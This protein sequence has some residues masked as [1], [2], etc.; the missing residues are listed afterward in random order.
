MIEDQVKKFKIILIGLLTLAWLSSPVA[1]DTSLHGQDV[2]PGVRKR[3]ERWRALEA[4]DP[5]K[6]RELVQQRKQEIRRRMLRLRAKDPTRFNALREELV[7]RRRERLRRLREENPEQFQ[8]VM[9][10]KW[11]RFEEWKRKNPTP[12]QAF[13]R[14]HPRLAE[15][16]RTHEE[17]IRAWAKRRSEHRSE[18]RWTHRGDIRKQ[19]KDRWDR[20]ENIRLWQEEVREGRE[21]QRRCFQN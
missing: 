19:R 9:R 11:N 2:A 6:F 12:Y 7:R 1:G 20:F 3:I 8:Q 18:D 4:K 21:N 17:K 13:L 14:G 15:R 5:E 10:R 16:I